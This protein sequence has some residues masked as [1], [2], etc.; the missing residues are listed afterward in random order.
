MLKGFRIWDFPGQAA[1]SCHRTTGRL[2]PSSVRHSRHVLE[3]GWK[4]FLLLD[5]FYVKAFTTSIDGCRPRQPQGAGTEI[6]HII[7]S[8]DTLSRIE[9][10]LSPYGA[11][12][13]VA[14]ACISHIAAET[15]KIEKPWNS[16]GGM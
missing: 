1:A 6:I 8:R 11:E 4:Q 12:S 2:I 14:I 7:L 9:F 10:P 5:R 15:M 13:E 16:R 3:F